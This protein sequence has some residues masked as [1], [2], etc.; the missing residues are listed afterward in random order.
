MF[1]TSSFLKN[2]NPDPL[3]NPQRDTTTQT[4]IFQKIVFNKLTQTI[5]IA[6]EQRHLSFKSPKNKVKDLIKHLRNEAIK[7]F[8]KIFQVKHKWLKFYLIILLLIVLTISCYMLTNLILSYLAFEV[9]TTARTLTEIKS[10]FPKVSICNVNPFQTEYALELLKQTNKELCVQAAPGRYLCPKTYFDA[11]IDL[12]Q[13]EV[14]IQTTSKNVTPHCKPP[15]IVE[16]ESKLWSFA[17]VI[18]DRALDIVNSN[19]TNEQKKLLA[20]NLDDLLINCKF[21]SKPCREFIWYFDS[22]Y[23]NCYMFNTGF[24]SSGHVI[25]FE[26]TTIPG[27]GFGLSLDFYVGM[28]ENLT[29]FNGLN[30]KTFGAIIKIENNSYLVDNG[31]ELEN[32]RVA[33]G[34]ET[35]IK[36]HRSFEFSLPRPYSNCDIPNEEEASYLEENFFYRLFLDSPYQYTRQGCFVQCYQQRLIQTCNCSD[37][38]LMSLFADTSVCAGCTQLN[39]HH[40]FFTSWTWDTCL[41]FCPF[42]CNRTRYVTDKEFL[43]LNGLNYALEIVMNSKLS[44]D[45]VTKQTDKESGAQSFISLNIFYDSLSYEWTVEKEKMNVVDLLANVGG[46]LSLFLGVSIFTLLEIFE[47]LLEIYFLK[48]N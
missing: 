34:L 15:D 33:A 37:Q 7:L 14:N 9:L 17:K 20:H 24:N 5:H 30:S 47:V 10:I 43:E 32:I 21:N 8:L 19:F 1:D 44:R 46:N 40:S 41:E 13:T 28:H 48:K 36:V 23:G 16:S 6:E 27:A 12:N 38:R 26:T 2:S 35:F 29:L 11:E 42:E 25:D 45:F 22:F 31:Y 4:D 3:L 39:C 18:H